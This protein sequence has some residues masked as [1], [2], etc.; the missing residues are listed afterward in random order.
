VNFSGAQMAVEAI[1]AN[2]AILRDY[3]LVLLETDTQCKVDLVMK[4]FIYYIENQTHPVAGILG[5]SD[6]ILFQSICCDVP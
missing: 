5:A 1:N 6:I 4:Q 3:E 2:D